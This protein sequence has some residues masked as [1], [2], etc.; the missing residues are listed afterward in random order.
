MGGASV[1]GT[2]RKW[3]IGCGIGCGVAL[4][5]ALLL[6]GGGYLLIRDVAH[7]AEDIEASQ[8]EL[9][10]R[11][12]A[13]ED[14]A[15]P[16]DGH[17]PA[18]RIEAFLDVREQSAP[19]RRKMVAR[20][21]VLD[22]DS[23]RGPLK[24]LTKIPAGLGLIPDVIAY[25]DARNE[26]LLASEMGLGEY[27]YVYTTGFFGALSRPPGAGPSFILTSDGDDDGP[28]WRHRP[29]GTV[30]RERAAQVGQ[31][32]NRHFLPVLRRQ[33]DEVAAELDD[34][35]ADIAST[36]LDTLRSE[37]AR[38]EDRPHRWPWQ[39]GLPERIA[40]S[41]APFTEQLAESWSP[42]ANP[43]EFTADDD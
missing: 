24:L 14:Y 1:A 29:P 16:L 27:L 36:W 32:L 17:L 39:D 30:T 12:G 9:I 7:R 21:E 3:L 13:I 37:I 38:L 11:Y 4:V 43:V 28:P 18:E 40:A 19:A 10:A 33:A 35:S 25:L 5:I 42:L 31:Y 26:A 2:G 6:A 23:T 22:Q 20:L 41:F 8:D 15:P 34:A